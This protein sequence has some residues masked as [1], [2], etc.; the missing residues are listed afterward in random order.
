MASVLTV[1]EELRE[2]VTAIQAT[3]PNPS[4]VRPATANLAELLQAAPDDSSFDLQSWQRQWSA[5]EAE[6]KAMT[7]TNDVAEGRGG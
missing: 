6:M 2:L 4:L 1:D 7:R 3:S 5:V